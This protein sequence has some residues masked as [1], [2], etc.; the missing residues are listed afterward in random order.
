MLDSIAQ[1]FRRED[2]IMNSTYL[3]EKLEVQEG[4]I[5]DDRLFQE[6][7]RK[8][9]NQLRRFNKSQK[10]ASRTAKLYYICQLYQHLSRLAQDF[11][12]AIVIVNQVSDYSFESSGS[13]TEAEAGELDYPL[14]LDFQTAVSSGWD[15][16]TIYNSIPTANITLKTRKSRIWKWSWQSRLKRSLINVKTLQYQLPTK[17]G[18]QLESS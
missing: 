14:N 7:K 15:S 1:H 17:A 9:M 16:R 13:F 12:I 6:V 11:N 5:A 18:T 3:K 10:Y 2:S 4:E 8:Q